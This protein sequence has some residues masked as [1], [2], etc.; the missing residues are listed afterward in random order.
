MSHSTLVT[1]DQLAPHLDDPNWVVIDCRFVLSD[2]AAGR[3]MY[4]DGHIPQAR[5]A[6]LDQDLSSPISEQSGRHPLPAPEQFLE[7]VKRWGINKHTQVV[8]YD[9]MGGALASRLWWLMRW[10][11]HRQVAVLEGGYPAWTAQG[12]PTT[13]D[14]PEVVPGDFQGTPDNQM[15]LTS[16][17]VAQ[18]LSSDTSALVDARDAA[19][20]RGEVEPVDPVAGHVPGAINLPFK[21]NLDEQ[22]RF[23]SAADLH[24][25]F[26]TV[27]GDRQPQD[28]VHMCG[29]G[30]TACHNIL[31][32]EVAGLSGS[33]LYAGSWSEWIRDEQRPV[34]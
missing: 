25:R 21:A 11:G 20:Y 18:N 3:A 30:V 23:L 28:I 26:Q 17:A 13:A 5:F 8:A 16:E 6:D 10:L 15:W 34:G 27:V 31:A 7:A 2:P 22:G 19:R 1:T 9:Q 4:I 12:L 33:R 24:A 14:L 32:M 29:S